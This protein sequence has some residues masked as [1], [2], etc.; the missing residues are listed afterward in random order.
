[1]ADRGDLILIVEDL[2][3]FSMHLRAG[4][5]GVWGNDRLDV[6]TWS[7]KLA[8]D[9]T[10]E[11]WDELMKAGLRA[12]FV[13]A[14]DF[15]RERDWSKGARDLPFPLAG[16]DVGKRILALPHPP[17]LIMYSDVLINPMINV[18]IRQATRSQAHGYYTA[19]SLRQ[20]AVLRSALHD[21]VP[22]GQFPEP[23]EED[24]A[25]FAGAWDAAH[26]AHEAQAKSDTGV[27]NL[28]VGGEEAIKAVRA[29]PE[30]ARDTTQKALR[31]LASRSG[32]R[33]MKYR[34]WDEI[35][36]RMYQAVGLDRTEACNRP[37]F[38]DSR[39]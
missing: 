12:V 5:L 9:S 22:I 29:L 31:R 8:F 3:G 36:R 7:H 11:Q 19:D 38:P 28:L 34:R 13:D 24:L 23:S 2:W 25:I 35:V 39:G 30:T 18:A 20:L 6:R 21:A 33:E 15:S 4:I 37:R 1:M 16:A 27:F 32:F 26:A 10:D 14:H 17:R